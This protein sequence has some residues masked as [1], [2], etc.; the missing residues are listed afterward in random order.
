MTAP[1][2]PTPP[3]GPASPGTLVFVY[4]TL[5]RGGANHHRLA[6]QT[7]VAATRTTPGWTLYA[8]EG[9]PGMVAAPGD[10]DGVTGELWRV[11]D[12]TLAALDEFEGVPEGLYRRE[13]VPLAGPP[14][15]AMPEA[16]VYARSVAG[17]RRLGS[18]WPA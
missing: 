13:R 4:G 1:G 16:Y 9:Y 5:K 12:T 11:D 2:R 3:P 7:F 15:N 18:T 6:D 10:A 8:L 14:A 17:R